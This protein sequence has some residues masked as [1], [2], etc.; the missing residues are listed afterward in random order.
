MLEPGAQLHPKWTNVIDPVAFKSSAPAA[1]PT[2]YYVIIGCGTGAIVNHTTLR[3]SSYGKRRIGNLPLLHIGF[4]DPWMHYVDH[5][6]GQRP[7]MLSLPGYTP[8]PKWNFLSVEESSKAF[9][10]RN[11]DQMAV[12][13]GAHQFSEFRAWVAM[14]QPRGMTATATKKEHRAEFIEQ[15]RRLKGSGVDINPLLAPYP[16]TCP[17]F[18]LLVVDAA[19]KSW[20]CYAE[21]VDLCTGTG[22]PRT[23]FHAGWKALFQ[24]TADPWRPPERWTPA[25]LDRPIMSGT[26]ALYQHVPLN[27]L[28]RTCVS[29]SAGVAVNVMER[30]EGVECWTDWIGST[31]HHRASFVNNP[32]NDS[33]LRNPATGVR[34]KTGEFTNRDDPK[35]PLL[36]AVKYW[37]FGSGTRIQAAKAAGLRQSLHLEESGESLPGF[38]PSAELRDW[39]DETAPLNAATGTFA[40]SNGVATWAV[41]NSEP[42]PAPLEQYDRLLVC[43]GQHAGEQAVGHPAQLTSLV[44]A[45]LSMQPI[46]AASTDRRIVGIG[47]SDT[48]QCIRIL[49]VAGIVALG[50]T[51][52]GTRSRSTRG[53][54]FNSTLYDEAYEATYPL[55]SRFP[56]HTLGSSHIAYAN[57]FFAGGRN[58]NVNT[59]SRHDLEMH[60][61]DAIL[62]DQVVSVRQN[63]WFGFGSRGELIQALQK[64]PGNSSM[65][66]KTHPP[67]GTLNYG[68]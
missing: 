8:Q 59:M 37:R 24:Y 28:Q 36:P 67:L 52:M 68:Y 33:L 4:D 60:C 53:V 3:N 21:K 9:A 49:G 22:R 10:D 26:E 16:A 57:Q 19:Q 32:R 42:L 7:W 41:A 63:G 50:E 29:G 51:G 15:C 65:T 6:M 46:L 47:S 39:L 5:R 66:T 18:R 45:V 31:T 61:G 48:E 43:S 2:G 27:K 58:A 25:E 1:T 20:L 30:C 14:I 62:A 11:V 55:Q 35:S 13:R 12:L 64:L 44:R 56:G 17:P 23:S 40:F 38:S 34:M 54:I